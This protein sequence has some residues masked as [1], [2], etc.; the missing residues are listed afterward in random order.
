MFINFMGIE[1]E[2]FEKHLSF[3]FQT[4]LSV[5]SHPHLRNIPWAGIEPES[6]CMGKLPTNWATHTGHEKH[7]LKPI[8][9][10]QGGT[11][12]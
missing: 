2:R 6:C 11:I 1:R 12:S 5:G 9:F 4:H 7:P 10:V 3:A 8:L